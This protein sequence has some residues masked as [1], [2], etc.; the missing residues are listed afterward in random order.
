VHDVVGDRLE[1][2]T[3]QE[4]AEGRTTKRQDE[5]GVAVEDAEPMAS[6]NSGNART[7]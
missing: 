7:W 1:K 3:E 2:L 6:T 5:R 4:N